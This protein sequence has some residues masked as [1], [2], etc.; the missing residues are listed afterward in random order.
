MVRGKLE[1]LVVLD[2]P[3]TRKIKNEFRLS[4]RGLERT[5]AFQGRKIQFLTR[6]RLTKAFLAF[7]LI[8][9]F[10]AD[11]SDILTLI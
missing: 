8:I 9:R 2:S 7:S 10:P 4:D 3:H 5:K 1:P 6:G 11:R